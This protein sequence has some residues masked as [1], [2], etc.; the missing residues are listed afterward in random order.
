MTSMRSL[1]KIIR[2][3]CLLHSMDAC[4][5]SI[6]KIYTQTG[7]EVEWDIEQQFTAI[8]IEHLARYV[9]CNFHTTAFYLKNLL[10]RIVEKC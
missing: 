5:F 6:K 3:R 9:K 10:D 8:V 7:S 2:R 1:Q 4:I